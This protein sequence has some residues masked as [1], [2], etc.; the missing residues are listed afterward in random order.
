MK[1]IRVLTFSCICLIVLLVI[2]FHV[3]A[4]N[5]WE[6]KQVSGKTDNMAVT[7]DMVGENKVVK[8]AARSNWE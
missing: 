1:K 2:P 4:Q 7:S 5:W 6:S 3:F 8:T